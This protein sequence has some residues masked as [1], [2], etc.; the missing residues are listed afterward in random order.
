M[1]LENQLNVVRRNRMVD[2]DLFN[3][4][5]LEQLKAV[6]NWTFSHRGV[7]EIIVG[8]TDKLIFS[9]EFYRDYVALEIKANKNW[10]ST[11]LTGQ[12]VHRCTLLSP[13]ID[14]FLK[15]LKKDMDTVYY[16]RYI[17]QENFKKSEFF[18]K[19]LS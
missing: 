17:E 1:S 14:N 2:Y 16:T 9:A 19:Y 5:V 12:E 8:S 11:L 7:F 4:G 3:S 10:L 13:E 15:S 18:K 6:K